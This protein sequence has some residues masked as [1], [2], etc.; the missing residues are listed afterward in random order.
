MLNYLRVMADYSS[1]C[2]WGEDGVMLRL[3][4]VP[5]SLDATEKLESWRLWFE[6]NNTYLPETDPRYRPFPLEEYAM[7]GMGVARMIKREM[8][9]WKITYYPEVDIRDEKGKIWTTGSAH[10]VDME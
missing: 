3:E 7:E 10:E 4:E 2:L 5:L 6:K 8:P 1:S 9:G